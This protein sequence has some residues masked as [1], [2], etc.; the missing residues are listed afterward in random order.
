MSVFKPIYLGTDGILAQLADGSIINIGGVIGPTFTVGG[1]G[2]LFD[3]GTSTGGNGGITLQSVYDASFDSNGDAKIKLITGRDLVIADDTD[4]GIFFK[5]DSETGKV[6]ITGDLEILG[7]AVQIDTIVQDSDHWLISPKAGTTTALKIEPDVGVTPVVDLITVRRLFGQPSVFRIDS[8]GNLIAT[9]NA[10]V[11]GDLNVGGLINGIDLVQLKDDLE[12]HFNGTNHRH[13][14]TQVD[15]DEIETLP[16]AT[17]VQE[18]LEQLDTK[19]TTG[20]VSG[21]EHVQSVAATTWVVS[22][23]KNTRRVI[24]AIYDDDYQLMIPDTVKLLDTNTA[25]IIFSSAITGRA[26]LSFF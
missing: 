2:L 21:Y 9:Q 13:L 10:D 15:I 8:N 6:T 17:N 12:D 26:M 7:N 22:H 24:P 25:V 5:I 19:V 16:G 18:A 14:A 11:G 1:R 20:G 4:D 23:N 3:D